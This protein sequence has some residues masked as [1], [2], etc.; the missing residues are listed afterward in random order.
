MI[1]KRKIVALTFTL[2][3]A[4]F[5][6]GSVVGVSA[7]SGHM[8]IWT[9]TT[10]TEDHVGT[11]EIMENGTTLDGAGY[12]II[13]PP[14]NEDYVIGILLNGKTGVTVKN[15]YV[16]LCDTGIVLTTNTSFNTI[17][18]NIVIDNNFDG[19][20]I[21]ENSTGNTITDNIANNN[22]D[23]YEGEPWGSGFVI[24]L[25]SDNL[26]MRNEASGNARSGFNLW[27]D[28]Q[29][30]DNNNIFIENIA[31]GNG[32]EGF[33]CEGSSGNT[34]IRNK[35]FDN[36]FGFDIQYSYR[37]TLQNNVAL[38]N[39]YGFQLWD[40][41]DCIIEY[42]KAH[43]NSLYGFYVINS[44]TDNTISWNRG[45]G[46]GIDDALQQNNCF[47]N[48]WENNR[49]GSEDGIGYFDE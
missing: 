47:R 11:I 3:I 2:I 5:L 19:I 16:T 35:A 33:Y 26:F 38:H 10:L 23:I 4:S 12:S 31:V 48:T 32:V 46:N 14:P 41:H 24:E 9:D 49:F 15:C 7:T 42:N 1:L 45:F 21:G 6:T 29:P 22:G 18:N 20:A 34:F 40:M 30:L 44:C 13:G 39:D 43:R 25:C 17:S 36:E 37:T 28:R 8:E 27:C